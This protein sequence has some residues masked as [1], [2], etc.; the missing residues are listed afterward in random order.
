MSMVFIIE[1]KGAMRV[2]E[3]P[4]HSAYSSIYF[5]LLG[6]DHLHVLAGLLLDVWLLRQLT[7]PLTAS[8]LVGLRA[9]TFYWHFINI[10]ALCVLG[11]QLS[12]RL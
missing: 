8:R 5:T 1:M 11:T 12:P 10:L 3:P 4:S 9:T 6:A 7:K 2:A